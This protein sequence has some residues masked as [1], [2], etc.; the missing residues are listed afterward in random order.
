[1]WGDLYVNKERLVWDLCLI[2][3]WVC[4]SFLVDSSVVWTGWSVLLSLW[5]VYYVDNGYFLRRWPVMSPIY[6]LIVFQSLLWMAGFHT[7]SALYKYTTSFCL[8]LSTLN[9]I[10]LFPA[11]DL[12]K[13]SSSGE[14]KKYHVGITGPIY[15]CDKQISIRVFYPAQ[16]TTTTTSKTMPYLCDLQHGLEMLQELL[17]MTAPWNATKE[18]DTFFSSIFYGW[19]CGNIPNATK[20]ALPMTHT[21]NFPCIIYSHGLFGN[22]HLYTSIA[23]AMAERGYIVVSL[24]HSDGSAVG[25]KSHDG[26]T[27][28]YDNSYHRKKNYSEAEKARRKQI[29]QRIQE[30]Q[31]IT[32]HLIQHS[33]NILTNTTATTTNNIIIPIDV[34]N[35][36]LMGHSYGGAT[37]LATALQQQGQQQQIYKGVIAHDP[38]TGWIP[39]TEREKLYNHHHTT[40]PDDQKIKMLL[41]YSQQW[42]DMKW[43]GIQQIPTAQYIS[44]THHSDFSD[45]CFLLP[46]W[47]AQDVLKMTGPRPPT[48]SA[49]EIIQRTVSFCRSCLVQPTKET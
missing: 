13:L 21:T 24:T 36:L 8:L 10:F 11:F 33:T 45:I 40:N 46:L 6:M 43:G 17:C 31:Q 35:I 47:L 37:V 19:S 7:S 14:E 23:H 9:G 39:D 48:Q 16:S 3:S 27:I 29:L 15:C 22:T 18:R 20:D 1:M 42:Y 34:D 25:A 38:A 30:C 44:G 4:S 2:V 28:P 32:Q 5:S 41:L 26:S 12:P 49:T